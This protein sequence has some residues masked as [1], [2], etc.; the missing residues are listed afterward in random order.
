M[1]MPKMGP[2]L[3]KMKSVYEPSKYI[4]DSISVIDCD[5]NVAPHSARQKKPYIDIGI[6]L[7]KMTAAI[8]QIKD[9][10]F[11]QEIF[12]KNTDVLITTPDLAQN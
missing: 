10:S 7:Y 6:F 3:Q 5:R 2:L 11:K 9:A 8:A 4:K 12:L 1:Y